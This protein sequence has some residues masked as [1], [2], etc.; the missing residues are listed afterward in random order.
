[1]PFCIRHPAPGTQIEISVEA[2]PL[3]IVSDDGAGIP[4]ED[5][6]HIF[7]RFWRAEKTQGKGVGLGLSI[8]AKIAA[9]HRG[10]AYMQSRRNGGAEFVLDLRPHGGAPPRTNSDNQTN[11]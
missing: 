8:V 7:G 11:W 1:M 6:P 4:Q 5:Q 2:G 10:R 9:M 3:V